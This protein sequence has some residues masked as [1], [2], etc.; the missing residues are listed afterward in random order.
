M[1][2]DLNR[3]F[4]EMGARVKF[5]DGALELPRRRW[6]GETPR[7]TL[8]IRRDHRGE[9]FEIRTL[10]GVEQEVVVLNAA[11]Q[12]RHLVL[13]SR[14]FGERRRVTKQKFLC[15]HDE[16]H[17]FVAAIPENAPVSTVASAKEALKPGEIREREAILGVNNAKDSF[18][19]R[20]AAFVRQGEWFFVPARDLRV[21]PQLVLQKEPLRR[22]MGSKAHY[23]EECYRTGG[24]GVYVNGKYP[25][26]LTEA[27]YRRL[28]EAERRSGQ[29]RY[30]LRDS[31][32][33]A[34]G[35][36]RHPDHATVVLDGW[37][38][39]WMNTENQARAMQNVVFL[40]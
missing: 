13:L 4:G 36:V 34:R 3:Y 6:Q 39:V 10:R 17:W 38:R 11:P 40:D 15:G 9:Y 23:V 16:R 2:S 8:D 25:T 33:F 37:H 1:R 12:D 21:N 24:V 7:I 26:G 35:E 22:G 30:M 19:R 32:V 27:D 5:L 20:N 31:A 18:R 29:F 28:P 14:Q